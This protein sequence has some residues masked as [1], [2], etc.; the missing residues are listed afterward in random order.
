LQLVEDPHGKEAAMK[1]DA[2]RIRLGLMGVG[3]VA[4]LVY[5]IAGGKTGPGPDGSIV[6]EYG[7]D[8]HAFEGASVEVDGALVG[9]LAPYG[10]ATRTGF[11]VKQ[12][13]RSVRV[14]TPAFESEPRRVEVAAGRTVMLIVDV[15][16]R[17]NDQGKSRPVVTFQ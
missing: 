15:Q 1:L 9:K 2:M 5:L 14:L 12:G 7:I 11:P 16:Q 13:L 4:F 3:L 8:S 6:I 17:A 10:S